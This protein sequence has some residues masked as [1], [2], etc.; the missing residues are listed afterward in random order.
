MN[1][2]DDLLQL[3]TPPFDLVSPA[4]PATPGLGIT[5]SRYRYG[6]GNTL[7]FA[8]EKWQP[9]HWEIYKDD[10]ATESL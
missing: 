2:R 1:S 10:S 6:G 8:A 9:R 4:T 5:K 3:P 7:G